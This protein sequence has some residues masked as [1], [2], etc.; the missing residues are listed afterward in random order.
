MRLFVRLLRALD[1]DAAERYVD[2]NPVPGRSED[3][4]GDHSRALLMSKQL[5]MSDKLRSEK[6]SLLAG[7]QPP[8][9]YNADRVGAQFQKMGIQTP[10]EERR[11]HSLRPVQPGVTAK[12]GRR[13]V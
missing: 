4:D 5:A 12:V 8:A 6:R 10:T 11:K 2:T 1:P 9:P 3:V 13:L 7:Y